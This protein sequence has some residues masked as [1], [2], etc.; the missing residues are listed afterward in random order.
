MSVRPETSKKLI[1]YNFF[2]KISEYQNYLIISWRNNNVQHRF[3][4]QL[5]LQHR[6]LEQLRLQPRISEATQNRTRLKPRF[7]E[8]N[9]I[10]KISIKEAHQKEGRNL[11]NRAQQFLKKLK[12]WK[13]FN[14]RSFWPLFTFYIF[15]FIF[16]RS[17]FV[18]LR[19]FAHI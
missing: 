11:V 5:R 8:D 4:E 3:L 19:P 16:Y 13:G 6:F 10:T 14:L 15:M 2:T 17:N 1:F 9:Q 7:W 18:L 12:N